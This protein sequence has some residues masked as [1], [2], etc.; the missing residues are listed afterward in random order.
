MPIETK[1]QRQAAGA[2]PSILIQAGS[3]AGK[4]TLLE[5]LDLERNILVFD[6]ENRSD[7]KFKNLVS[8]ESWQHAKDIAVLCGGPQASPGDHRDYSA[9]HFKRAKAAHPGLYER[10]QTADII[11]FDGLARIND[12]CW[13][14]LET[15]AWL[16]KKD[17]TST[18]DALRHFKLHG[19]ALKP[20]FIELSFCRKTKVFT[21]ILEQKL[22]IDQKSGEIEDT[23]YQLQMQ[24]K[25]RREIKQFMDLCLVLSAF[26]K[27]GNRLVHDWE[28]KKDSL[29]F[30][31]AGANNWKMSTKDSSKALNPIEAANLGAILTKIEAAKPSERIAALEIA[32]PAGLTF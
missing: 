20:F 26:T 6:A 30:I 15:D 8:V 29:R 11:A 22:K 32:D 17:G 10:I 4:T 7:T 31:V 18:Y 25:M 9:A 5:R 1:S 23:W 3:G 21:S 24:G 19:E 12:F 27:Q 2:G 13:E 14:T 28:M 16:A